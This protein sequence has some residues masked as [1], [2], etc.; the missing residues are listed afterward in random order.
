MHLADIEALGP[1]IWPFG[2]EMVAK[3]IKQWILF[4]KV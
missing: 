3:N 1:K 2:L 4:Y